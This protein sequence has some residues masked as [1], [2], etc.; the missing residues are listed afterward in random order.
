MGGAHLQ[1]PLLHAC[2]HLVGDAA[3]QAGS[4]VDDIDEFLIDFGRQVFVHLLTV[5]HI[6]P[7]IF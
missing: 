1:G 7:E 5:E 6:L 2:S 3:I 4:I